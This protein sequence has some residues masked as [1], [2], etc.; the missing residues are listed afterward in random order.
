MPPRVYKSFSLKKR[1][2]VNA[3]S[4]QNT[5]YMSRFVEFLTYKVEK[6]GKRVIRIDEWNIT[7]ACCK[8]GKLKKRALFERTIHCDCGNHMD[9]DSN[10]EINIMAKFLHSKRIYDFLSQ[11]SSVDE[12]SFLLQWNGFL[13]HTG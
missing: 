6:P 11:E 12:E 5:G 3:N 4:I 2:V 10:S 8:C 13:R 7:K 1:N 9:R